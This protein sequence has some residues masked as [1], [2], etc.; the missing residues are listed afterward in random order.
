MKPEDVHP[1]HDVREEGFLISD[2][3]CQTCRH[4]VPSKAL[5]TEC[6]GP[7]CKVP[8]RGWRCTRAAGHEGPCAAEPIFAPATDDW[9]ARLWWNKATPGE[10]EAMKRLIANVASG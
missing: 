1:S 6:P 7:P 9:W 8:P 2:P 5:L 4:A 3:V 10:R